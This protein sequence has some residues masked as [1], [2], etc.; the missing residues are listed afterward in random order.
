MAPIAETLT[1]WRELESVAGDA[2]AYRPMPTNRRRPPIVR[3]HYAPRLSPKKEKG[4]G[5]PAPFSSSKESSLERKCLLDTPTSARNQPLHSSQPNKFTPSYVPHRVSEMKNMIAQDQVEV[6]L[7]AVQG[8]HDIIW[9]RRSGI[10][11]PS[12]HV[13]GLLDTL[14]FQAEDKLEDKRKF[15]VI[16]IRPNGRKI[17]AL[18]ESPVTYKNCVWYR[19]IDS[20]MSCSAPKECVFRCPPELLAI[21]P[22]A[23]RCQTEASELTQ[24]VSPKRWTAARICV[25]KWSAVPTIRLVP[26]SDLTEDVDTHGDYSHI[27]DFTEATEKTSECIQQLYDELPGVPLPRGPVVLLRECWVVSIKWPFVHF[28][29]SN[30]YEKIDLV[31]PAFANGCSSDEHSILDPKPGSLCMVRVG[32]RFWRAAVTCVEGD[33]ANVVFVD[34]GKQSVRA[35]GD[36]LSLLPNKRH[37]PPACIKGRLP[38][39]YVEKCFDEATLTLLAMAAGPMQVLLMRVDDDIPT[40]RLFGVDGREICS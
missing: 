27:L 34:N 13:Q 7:D 26:R 28:V 11:H 25:L 1:H 21:P 37:A 22:G 9:V 8:S 31:D 20:G 12:A 39:D 15:P 14:K 24:H 32:N 19:D 10:K 35:V 3:N 30:V 23:W 29:Q 2:N 4:D 33:S 36:L 40:V 38:D 6:R 17:R 18:L 5:I 16:I